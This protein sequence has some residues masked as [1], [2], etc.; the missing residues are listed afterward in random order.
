MVSDGAITIGHARAPQSPKMWRLRDC[1]VGVSG[2]LEAG[3]RFMEWLPKRLGKRPNGNYSAL[4][5]YRDGRIAWW[6]N[7]HRET[8]IEEDYYSIGSGSD[9]ALGAFEAMIDMGLPIDPRVAVRSAIK[10]DR[11]SEEPVHVLRW[12]RNGH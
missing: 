6:H 1:I 4:V 3:E 8:F 9:F 2:D 11:N 5:L 12:K 10:R 7:R